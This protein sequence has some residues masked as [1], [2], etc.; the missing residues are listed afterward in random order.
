MLTKDQIRAELKKDPY[1]ELPDE[2][3]NQEWQWYDEIYEELEEKG[4]L[5]FSDDGDDDDDSWD[6]DN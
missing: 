5:N 3:S 2:A 4:E 6:D 1:W